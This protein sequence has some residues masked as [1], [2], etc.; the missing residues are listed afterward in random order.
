MGLKI[1]LDHYQAQTYPGLEIKE[2]H[3]MHH[4]ELMGKLL[5][6]G[7]FVLKCCVH[8]FKESEII[9]VV[10]ATQTIGTCDFCG[11]EHI[12]VM[13]YH[14]IQFLQNYSKVFCTSIRWLKICLQST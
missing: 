7:L 1:L 4:L 5:D 11:H 12:A 6:G 13:K 10:E 9:A 14:Q 2:A 8:C 3:H